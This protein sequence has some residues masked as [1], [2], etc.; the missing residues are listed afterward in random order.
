MIT[1]RD[2]PGNKWPWEK[3]GDGLWSKEVTEIYG[4]GRNIRKTGAV[5]IQQRREKDGLIRLG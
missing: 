3:S 4:L 5:E 1:L 2:S